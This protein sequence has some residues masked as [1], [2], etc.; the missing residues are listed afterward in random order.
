MRRRSEP[1]VLDERYYDNFPP[2]N[3]SSQMPRLLPFTEWNG[4]WNRGTPK[5]LDDFPQIGNL[6]KFG[7]ESPKAAAAVVALGKAA[8]LLLE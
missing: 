4:S 5:V 6:E 1:N 7:N 8:S 2:N 3:F